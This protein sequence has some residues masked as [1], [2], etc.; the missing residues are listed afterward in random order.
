MINAHP[1]LTV[2]FES[3]FIPDTYNILERYGDLS[4]ADNIGK[5]LEYIS[6]NSF[7]KRGSLITDKE[8]ILSKGPH[9]YSELIDA[10]YSTYA[11]EHG[12]IRW[13][14]KD[15]SYSTE[16]DVLYK[17]FPDCYVI[18]IVR[19]GRDV[20]IS[21]RSLSWG[22]KHLLNVARRWQWQVTLAHKMGSMLGNR[23]CEIRH[24]DLVRQPKEVLQSICNFLG[25]DFSENMLEYHRH[26]KDEMPTDSLKFHDTSVSP[27]NLDKVELWKRE[28]S[29]EDIILFEEIA[30]DT[31]KQFGYDLLGEKPDFRTKLRNLKY[32]LIFRW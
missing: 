31:L 23:F 29:R 10:I 28:M 16:I 17:L 12:K 5:L 20:A 15:P 25:E 7:V 1:N 2:P 13:G 27:P 22:S 14:D 3:N 19:D 32:N 9:S 24:E 18:H 30:G 4:R 26:A 11:D 8:K 21:N 6:E